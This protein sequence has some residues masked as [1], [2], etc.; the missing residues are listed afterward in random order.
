MPVLNVEHVAC[1][2]AEPAAMAAWY[3]EHLGMR[4]VRRLRTGPWRSGG[5]AR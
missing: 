2:V 5:P 3:V 4:I 1:N